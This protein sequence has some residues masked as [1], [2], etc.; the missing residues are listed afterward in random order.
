MM[1][2]SLSGMVLRKLGSMRPVSMP[3]NAKA[4]PTAAS[5]NATG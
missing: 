2:N 1:P 4:R 3:K 5:E